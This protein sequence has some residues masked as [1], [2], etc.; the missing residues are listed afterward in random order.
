MSITWSDLV[1]MAIAQQ[2]ITIQNVCNN[3]SGYTLLPPTMDVIVE[4]DNCRLSEP[5][6]VDKLGIS[7]HVSYIQV[8]KKLYAM[9]LSLVPEPVPYNQIR[10]LK[11]FPPNE[12]LVF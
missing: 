2:K 8:Q 1:Q 4:L 12:G 7:S 6:R 10:I 5:V 3:Q 9:Y 11:S